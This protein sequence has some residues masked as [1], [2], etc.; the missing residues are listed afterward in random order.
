M[1]AA[2]QQPWPRRLPYEVYERLQGVRWSAL[3][4][5]RRSAKHYRHRLEE[6]RKDEGYYRLGRAV[7]T[8]VFEPDRLPLD[9][10]IWRG[11]RKVGNEWKAFQAA[12]T[13]LTI[14]KVEE[15]A[16]ACAIRDAVRHHP[17]A[18][19][20]L[21]AGAAEQSIQWED[22]GTMTLCKAR[23]DWVG[24][25][26]LV[27]LKTARS[28]DERTFSRTIANLAYHCQL[29]F[30]HRGM[31]TLGENLRPILIAVES[32]PPHDVA[33]YPLHEN[34]LYAGSEEVS[35]LLTQLMRAEE[36]QTW[37]RG[38]YPEEVELDI[39]A[40]AYGDDEDVTETLK[41]TDTEAA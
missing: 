21:A 3:R 32:E 30:Y 41:W 11:E 4:E 25:G 2:A 8:A 31:Q 16:R 7:H 22:P 5:L 33:V 34:A 6:P 1:V 36:G 23:L 14:L 18:S 12:H 35:D 40:W 13:G 28:I 19:R 10:A 9:Y 26:A 37:D 38:R 15:Y 29:A 17:A 27:D 24:G 39:P 20:Y